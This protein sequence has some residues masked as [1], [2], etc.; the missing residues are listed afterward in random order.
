MIE[1]HLH[2]EWDGQCSV[3]GCENDTADSKGL[4]AGRA[5]FPD[6]HLMPS[7]PRYALT[8]EAPF[9]MTHVQEFS[10]AGK[11]HLILDWHD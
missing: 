8:I 4:I 2:R 9:C 10:D 7:D 1:V 5:D 11:V 3:K 6:D